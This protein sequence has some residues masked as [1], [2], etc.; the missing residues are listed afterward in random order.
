MKTDDSKSVVWSNQ[1]VS[2]SSR[3][4]YTEDKQNGLLKPSA[5]YNNLIT[6]SDSYVR[7][8]RHEEAVAAL[9]RQHGIAA[10]ALPAKADGHNDY[11][12]D[13]Y[14]KLANGLTVTL[15]VK[16]ARNNRISLGLPKDNTSHLHGYKRYPRSL[17]VDAA[18]SWD[19]KCKTADERSEFLLGALLL[20]TIGRLSDEE[21]TTYGLVYCPAAF[22][23]EWY[24][25]DISRDGRTYTG[26]RCP[27]EYMRNLADLVADLEALEQ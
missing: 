26:L 21:H 10:Q 9:L 24:E 4:Q 19:N 16:E 23:D 5:T 2:I 14:I 20:V 8:H 6:W 3:K 1:H 25:E 13:L 7:S 12:A 27:R 11:E 18:W 15:E 22:A 17:I